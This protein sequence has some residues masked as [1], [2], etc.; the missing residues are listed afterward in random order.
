MENPVNVNRHEMFLECD[1]GCSFLK[2]DYWEDDGNVIISHNVPS[3][4]A[5]QTNTWDRFKKAVEIIWYI[6]RGK[7]YRFYEICLNTKSK[8]K[9]FKE[10]VK[11]IDES[12][13]IYD[14]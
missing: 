4:Y 14:D 3:W 11:N 1:C 8:I 5:L 10:F 13:L 12:K 9:E 7:E 6:I 2:I